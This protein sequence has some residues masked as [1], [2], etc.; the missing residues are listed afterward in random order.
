MM[1]WLIKKREG[2]VMS[3]RRY[4]S[5]SLLLLWT[6][7]ASVAV[8]AASSP[9]DPYKDPLGFGPRTGHMRGDYKNAI[10]YNGEIVSGTDIT[11]ERNLAKILENRNTLKLYIWPLM[12]YVITSLIDGT[13]LPSD[14]TTLY[15]AFEEKYCKADNVFK[16]QTTV[17]PVIALFVT[18]LMPLK[19]IF[20]NEEQ[21]KK[22]KYDESI[23]DN[24]KKL[25]EV[26]HR[27]AIMDKYADLSL[28]GNHPT[29]QQVWRNGLIEKNLYTQ[30]WDEMEPNLQEKLKTLAS[31]DSLSF[32][33][34]LMRSHLINSAGTP[35]FQLHQK[36]LL[37]FQHVPAFDDYSQLFIIRNLL[38]IKDT[39]AVGRAIAG[40]KKVFSAPFLP[41]TEHVVYSI[42]CYYEKRCGLPLGFEEALRQ[43]FANQ[44]SDFFSHAEQYPFMSFSNLWDFPMGG[45]EV[46]FTDLLKKAAIGLES[47]RLAE[48]WAMR[49][50][51]GCDSYA[52]APQ[53]RIKTLEKAFTEDF[54]DKPALKIGVGEV[55]VRA[56]PLTNL[57]TEIV[58]NFRHVKLKYLWENGVTKAGDI[59]AR[60]YIDNINS[61]VQIKESVLALAGLAFKGNNTAQTFFI[62]PSVVPTSTFS[63]EPGFSAVINH[64]NSERV[65]MAKIIDRLVFL[66][67]ILHTPHSIDGGP[68]DFYKDA[69]KF[70]DLEKNSGEL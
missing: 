60:Y 24:N 22:Q 70:V 54:A 15:Q 26:L 69:L 46:N 40:W 37:N 58:F 66:S 65:V 6:N 23:P 61:Y 42:L 19:A 49:V 5:C 11:G 35:L 20:K 68:I 3:K 18:R 53:T 13:T 55:L 57:L 38:Q 4:L 32:G 63:F 51:S 21:I 52:A 36:M 62:K 31:T 59:L 39:S 9:F 67:N 8:S 17:D 50:F 33:Y 43:S 44:G 64:M 16:D 34:L 48:I 14:F 7:V 56:L 1:L 47:Q 25:P 27:D 41:L 10:E 45:K 29:A 2:F 12:K 30:S 28:R